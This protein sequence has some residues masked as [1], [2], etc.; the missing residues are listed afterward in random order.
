MIMIHLRECEKVV[1]Q[2]R[3]LQM[4]NHPVHLPNN[5]FQHQQQIYFS[6]LVCYCYHH[7]IPNQMELHSL[8]QTT[9]V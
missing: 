3:E 7:I 8:H 9:E 2:L 5:C 4:M 6:N 1:V